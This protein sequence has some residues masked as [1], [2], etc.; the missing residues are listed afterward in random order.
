M[1]ARQED[2]RKSGEHALRKRRE[3]NQSRLTEEQEL[4]T[5]DIQELGRAHKKKMEELMSKYE[6]E[7]KSRH[8]PELSQVKREL[9]NLQQHISAALDKKKASQEELNETKR[10]I[11][12]LKQTMAEDEKRA[13]VLAESVQKA[14]QLLESIQRSH[15]EWKSKIVNETKQKED[16][17]KRLEIIQE[18]EFWEDRIR[19]HLSFLFEFVPDTRQNFH[20]STASQSDI[21]QYF[22]CCHNDTETAAEETKC[23]VHLC[24]DEVA[25][26]DWLR[27]RH[28]IL[29]GNNPTLEDLRAIAK[30][31]VVEENRVKGVY[32]RLREDAI[33]EQA[34]IEKKRDTM[35]QELENIQE[36]IK[37]GQAMR[38][39]TN[40]ELIIV[41][42]SL[43]ENQQRLDMDKRRFSAF[44]TEIETIETRLAESRDR[45]SHLMNREV[46]HARVLELEKVTSE[47]KETVL[48]LSN[49]NKS[50]IESLNEKNLIVNE[51]RALLESRESM[52][53]SFETEKNALRKTLDSQE[54]HIEALKE[55]LRELE[56]ELQTQKDA[57]KHNA[58]EQE[59]KHDTA[60]ARL[61]KQWVEKCAVEVEATKKTFEKRESDL[62][63]VCKDIGAE[64]RALQKEIQVASIQ[65][66]N[67]EKENN[68][69]NQLL[70]EEQR[71]RSDAVEQTGKLKDLVE[72]ITNRLETYERKL[73]ASE[74]DKARLV[75]ELN[76]MVEEKKEDAIKLQT[77]KNDFETKLKEY[78]KDIL[79]YEDKIQLLKREND[80]LAEKNTEEDQSSTGT[81]N[82]SESETKSAQAQGLKAGNAVESPWDLQIEN[83][84]STSLKW[85]TLFDE[86]ELLLTNQKQLVRQLQKYL[87]IDQ[88]DW[89]ERRYKYK[90]EGKQQDSA[91]RREILGS[92]KQ[93]KSVLDA[94]A[95]ELNE[96]VRH[97]KD[98]IQW[99][100]SQRTKLSQSKSNAQKE[101]HFN[102]IRSN[103]RAYFRAMQKMLERW[104]SKRVSLRGPLNN[105]FFAY[106]YFF[107][108]FR[109]STVTSLVRC[110]IQELSR[111]SF[112]IL[113]A[114]LILI[115]ANRI[116]FGKTQHHHQRMRTNI[117]RRSVCI[118]N[119]NRKRLLYG[120]SLIDK[121]TEGSSSGV[122]YIATAARTYTIL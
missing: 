22:Q 73:Q 18:K 24:G 118:I 95:S 33:L 78:N 89:T 44:Q 21:F 91:Y 49:E 10:N 43:S 38:D 15:A 25:Q 14:S 71:A 104:G 53:H 105:V 100:G 5:R 79:S 56:L 98:I 113:V 106:Y 122:K 92:L 66:K 32:S 23:I 17:R 77:L 55:T 72:S 119:S 52:A 115:S 6:K 85:E 54:G 3:R 47:Q 88:Q 67:L 58:E 102:S 82:D 50:M 46:L 40:D 35:L 48:Q 93:R 111:H 63:R 69:F 41:R 99:I 57:L 62:E 108:I 68:K 51:Q 28:Q 9:V 65:C 103:F 59:K 27:A 120:L 37:Q 26:E 16:E 81:N 31:L 70:N 29:L 84:S 13:S 2:V 83:D 4:Y 107:S 86:T 80:L 36:T 42:R 96:D 121:A 19:F 116:H 112:L 20:N 8:L 7:E 12:E 61:E 87:Q 75:D 110:L 30:Q 39:K 94:Q 97:L 60:L 34:N 64:N 101:N 45:H 76:N 114:S 74:H 109:L 117:K 11:A 90:T 1:F